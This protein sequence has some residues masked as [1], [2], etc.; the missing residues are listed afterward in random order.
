MFEV[1]WAL[2]FPCTLE[3]GEAVPQIPTVEGV[4]VDQ[5]VKRVL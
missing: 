2:L 4:L 1:V 3:L 5:L